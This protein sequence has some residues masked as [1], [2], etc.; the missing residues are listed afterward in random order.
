MILTKIRCLVI[1][2]C[3]HVCQHFAKAGDSETS[4][5]GPDC[6]VLHITELCLSWKYLKQMMQSLQ[7]MK[8]II[9]KV[10]CC[11]EELF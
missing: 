9:M 6:E 2:D 4:V 7:R 8:M 5:Y 10:V 1:I 3:C 11:L